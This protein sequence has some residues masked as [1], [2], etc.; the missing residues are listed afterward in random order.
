MAVRAGRVWRWASRCVK[1]A[2]GGQREQPAAIEHA[3][4]PVRLARRDA[5]LAAVDC[6]L[7]ESAPMNLVLKFNL[8]LLSTVA[9]GL[10]A[11]AV[12]G[13]RI[14]QDRARQETVQS[15]RMM[16][17]T[18]MAT[19]AYTSKH[20]SGLIENQMKY[21]FLPQ[22]IPSFAATEVLKAMQT[23][24]P[25]YAYKEATLNPTNP[26]DRVVDW[27]AD[28]VQVFRRDATLT[29]LVGERAT[30]TGMS[31][32]L[33]R[34]I[35]I[36]DAACLSCHSTPGAAP[37]TLT[38]KYGPSN[39]FGWKQGETVGA[40]IVSVP[41]TVAGA[42]AQNAFQ[43]FMMGVGAVFAAVFV[44]LNLLLMLMV[45]RPMKRLARL[46]EQA[47]LGVED[48][49]QFALDRKDEIGDLARAFAR[50]RTSLATA[51]KMI[52]T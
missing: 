17:E 44:V 19:R 39:G 24:Y 11:T 36:K 8:V 29:E 47:S 23:N 35:T 43:A 7:L 28:V 15:A 27:E 20:V 41:S 38:D 30:P 6:L 37:K 16:L 50:M 1:K 12:L 32:Y 46:T 3:L 33:A 2:H 22:S 18:A 48:T 52:E 5:D 49:T 14:L 42:A 4:E 26:R 10:A 51:M 9:L 34:P 40:Q 21:D 25:D 31:L 45:I 13:Q